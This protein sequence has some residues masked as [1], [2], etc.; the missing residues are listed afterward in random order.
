MDSSGRMFRSK[1]EKLKSNVDQRLLRRLYIHIPLL[2]ASFTAPMPP[3]SSAANNKAPTANKY[4]KPN[5][6]QLTTQLIV[7]SGNQANSVGIQNSHLSR[8]V[9]VVA[10]VGTL[11]EVQTRSRMST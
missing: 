2:S 5:V 4:A 8:S 3:L 9:V 1:H 7:D 10:A 11:S 6:K